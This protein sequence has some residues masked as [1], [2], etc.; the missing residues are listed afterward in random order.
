MKHTTLVEAM[1]IAICATG[2]MASLAFALPDISLT[3]SVSSFPLH[4]NFEE[5]SATSAFETTSGGILKGTGAKILFL[6]KALSAL[7]TFNIAIENVRSGS[8]NCETPGDSAGVVL[9]DGS[10][11]LVYTSLAPLRL[12]VLYEVT[13]F[14]LDCEGG[15]DYEIK[16]TMIVSLNGIGT[17]L[18]ELTSISGKLSGTKGA[19]E[20]KEYYND[21][22]TKIRTELELN[23]GGGFRE[24]NMV[25]EGEPVLKALGSNMFVITGR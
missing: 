19:Q 8:H 5:A 23:S 15:P 11:G 12:G 17:E 6:V 10:I 13:P 16:G 4:L 18:T 2:L 25:I 7:G 9:L 21:G 24:A 14:E 22:G 3:L 20:I 1:L